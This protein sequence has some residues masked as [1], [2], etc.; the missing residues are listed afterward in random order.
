MI[1]SRQ[2]RNQPKGLENG[3][4][5]DSHDHGQDA[6]LCKRLYLYGRG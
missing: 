5:Q 4:H 2:Q 1:I 6:R 3:Y